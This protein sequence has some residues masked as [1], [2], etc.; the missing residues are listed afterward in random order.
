MIISACKGRKGKSGMHRGDPDK[1]DFPAEGSRM[2][3]E[4]H[5]AVSFSYLPYFGE[6]PFS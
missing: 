5:A 4:R 1:E 3:Q 2:M 6:A